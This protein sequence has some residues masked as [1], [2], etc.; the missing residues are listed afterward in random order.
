M[1]RPG[2]RTIERVRPARVTRV[3]YA[4]A[5]ERRSVL[6]RAHRGDIEGGLGRVEVIDAGPRRSLRRR[7]STFAAIMGPGIVVM[8]ADNDAGGISTYAEAGQDHGLR[9]V[10]LLVLLA[11]VL[12][13]TQEMVARLGA[14]TGVGHARLILERF[15]RWWGMFALTDLV[16]LSFLTIVTEFIGI[17]LALGHFGVSKFAAV[18]L[19]AVGLAVATVTGSF[20]RW[21]RT[22][23]VLVALS[24]LS[25]PLVLLAQS[26]TGLLPTTGATADTAQ[27][28]GGTVMFVIALVGTTVAPWQLFFQ[29]SYIVDKRIT[30]RWLNYVRADTIL[31]T[32]LFSL[33]AIAVMVTCALSFRSTPLQGAFTDAGHVADGLR[34]S[35]GSWTGALFAVLLLTGSILGAGAVS[36]ATSYAVGDVVGTKHSLHRP[37]RDAKAFHGCFVTLIGVAAGI[38][39]IPGAPLGMVTAGV[40]VLAGVLLPSAT[41]FLLLLCN[42]EDVLGPWTNARWLNI[43][44]ASIVAALVALSALLTWSALFGEVSSLAATCAVGGSIVAAAAALLLRPRQRRAHRVARHQA[45]DDSRSWSMPPLD[46]LPPPHRSAGRTVCLVVLRAYLVVAS[47]VVVVKVV[48]SIVG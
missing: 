29:Q 14:V 18:P 10:W 1:D 4:P 15:G 23:F 48:G 35:A 2:R 8:V 13:V 5:A 27:L 45:Q 11:P 24:L 46:T 30:P 41:V 43:V 33:G 25:I 9:L 20:R 39:L 26:H 7:I 47:V 17:A 31:G 37:W 21:E 38:V 40:Q 32:G 22:M 3:P 36:L 19:A 42:D 34:H 28:G 6:D 16:L 12:F 44:S